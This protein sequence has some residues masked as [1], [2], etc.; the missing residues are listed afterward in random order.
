MRSITIL[1]I[2][3]SDQPAKLRYTWQ[4]VKAQAVANCLSFYNDL[5][6]MKHTK[7]KRKKEKKATISK[8][9]VRSQK[10]KKSYSMDKN[11]GAG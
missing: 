7:Q 11:K 4:K 10:L 9:N 2:M 5:I 1:N 8:L 3:K 6:P